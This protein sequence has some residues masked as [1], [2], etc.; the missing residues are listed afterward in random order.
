MNVERERKGE[1]NKHN[2]IGKLEFLVH[3][4]K[5]EPEEFAQEENW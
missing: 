3:G 1:P 5:D 4:N 2:T